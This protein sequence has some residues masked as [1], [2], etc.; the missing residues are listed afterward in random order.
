M[1]MTTLTIAWRRMRLRSF[2]S[3]S[4]SRTAD[5]GGLCSCD[6]MINSGRGVV[7]SGSIRAWSVGRPPDEV[8]PTAVVNRAMLVL[9]GA[10]NMEAC[11][12]DDSEVRGGLV[13]SRRHV[14]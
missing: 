11:G 1:P 4:L 2:L 8:P 10:M 9:M 7:L 6:F 3:K 13:R 14:D 5:C 12:N